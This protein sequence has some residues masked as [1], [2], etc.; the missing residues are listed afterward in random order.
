MGALA[1]GDAADN[2]TRQI[3]GL[4]A[5]TDDDDAV[6][7]AQLKKATAAAADAAN[8][9]NYFHTNATGQV[10]TGNTSNLDDVDGIGGAKGIGAIA[11]GMNAVAEGNHAVV[12]GGNG[13]NKATGG[14]AVAMGRNTLASGS[15]SVAMGNNAQATGG[16]ST[17]MGQQSLASGILST[18][19][20]VKTKA[21]GDSSTA[22]GEETQAVGYA[23]TSTG[24]KTVASGVTAFTSG[25]ETKAEGDYSAAFG[26]KS[27]A[28]GIGSFVTGGSQKYVDGNPVAGKQGGIAYS[29]GSIA[30]GT[31]TV[32]GKQKLGQAEAMLQ[33]VQ[34]Y[35]AEQNVTLT[36]Q[37]DLN[38]PA[39]IQAA[40]MELAQKTG[41]TP[42]ELMDALIPSATKLSAGPE[43]VAM[44]YRSQAIAED[45]MALGFD[46]KA[47]HE[48]SVALGSQAIT[49]EEVDVNEATVGG[50][51][52]G[53][54]AGTPD[55]VV[56]IGKKDHE[57]QLINVAAGEISQTSTDA[58]NGSQLYATN[59][60]IGNVANSVKT[61]F[62][63]N[64][65]LQDDGTITF[66]DIGGT[67]EDTIHDAIKSVKTEAAKHSEVKQ[68][69]N[70]LVSKT[71]GADGHAIYTVNAEGTNVAAGSADVIVSSSTDSTS[72]DTNYSVKLSDEF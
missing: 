59:V 43:A 62:G 39:T 65:N 42:P 53:N 10:Q 49:R 20:G 19:M 35:A 40:I 17:A 37:V 5:G 29:D 11:I 33:A 36:T 16:G 21:T 12:I 4:A 54:F 28:L 2:K 24:L 68:G 6:N 31:E 41:K 44:G 47:E 32:A 63:G 56:S 3:T 9:Q 64:A 48:N 26:V 50:I 34:E 52:Y 14:Y 46:A 15:G 27:K 25:N 58:I 66:T 22:M 18:A 57:K 51:K 23:S 13:T 30:M 8:K 67:G 1:I 61:N 69:T 7:V 70:V 45:T 72:N 71:S 38:N 60:A 55:G